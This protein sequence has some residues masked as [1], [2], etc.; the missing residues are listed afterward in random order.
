MKP[1]VS[2]DVLSGEPFGKGRPHVVLLGA[3]ASRAAFPNGDRNGRQLPLMNE[4]P[5]ILG[6][7]WIDLISKATPSG[8]TFESQFSWLV[9]S[10][11]YTLQ[12]VEIESAIENYFY[13]LEIPDTPTLYDLLILG[14]REKDIIATFNWDPL[15]LQAHVRNRSCAKLPD[16]RFLHGCLGYATCLNHDVLGSSGEIC[17]KC[18]SELVQSKLF[19]PSDCK[20]YTKDQIVSR[21]WQ[22][23]VEALRSAFHLTIFGYSGPESDFKARELLLDGWGSRPNRNYSHVEIIDIASP[24]ELSKNWKSFIPFNHDMI[25]DNFEESTIS[26]WPRRTEEF[27]ESASLY[28]QVCEQIGPGRF[29]T[30]A[31]LQNWIHSIAKKEYHQK[32]GHT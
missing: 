9:N 18:G 22:I 13:S 19:Y 23:T 21:D 15:L 8:S 2:R 10:A 20:D 11:R 30:L 16:I 27:K 17:P 32:T 29:D 24:S 5:N 26:K 6:R 28:G 4:L 1:F 7:I 3:G 14:L 31:Q 12:L 25:I